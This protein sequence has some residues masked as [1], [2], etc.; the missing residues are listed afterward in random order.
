MIYQLQQEPARKIYYHPE[1]ISEQ[2]R[3]RCPTCDMAFFLM[4]DVVK[5][6]TEETL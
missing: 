6:A 4:K 1:I 3:E 2:H 5:T